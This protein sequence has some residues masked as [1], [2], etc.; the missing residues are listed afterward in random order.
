M[1]HDVD[2]SELE[3]FKYRT[4]DRAEWEAFEHIVLWSKIYRIKI[5]VYCYSMNMQTIDGDE[6]ISE[7]E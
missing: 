7:K 1:Q 4:I 2:K 5:E 3:N 6:F